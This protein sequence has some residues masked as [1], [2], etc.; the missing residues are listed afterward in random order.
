MRRAIAIGGALVLA[1]IGT[2]L[3]VRY[4]QTAEDRAL[5]GQQLVEVLVVDD[6]IEEGTRGE[7]MLNSLRREEVPQKVA[8][9]G[10]ISDPA[11]LEGLVAETDLVPDE[12]VIAARFIT[13]EEYRERLAADPDAV[14]VPSDRL[15]VTLSLSPD[16]A[17]GGVPR[18]GDLVAVFA[19]FDP[20]S[21]QFVEPGEEIIPI[22]IPEETEPGV[23]EQPTALQSPNSTQIIL[24]KILVTNVQAEEL[25]P[26]RPADENGETVVGGPELVATG[27]FLITLALLPEEAE[28]VVFTAEHGAVWLAIEGADVDESIT[29]VKTRSNIYRFE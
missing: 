14:P 8:A 20:F 16:R 9:Q 10:V 26:E 11:D 25:P 6:F 7:D 1:L 2:F 28:R 15:E 17:V 27:N 13:E 29:E 3:L 12:Q 5:E 22:I 24:H 23:I 21:V 4:V 19:S 18:P